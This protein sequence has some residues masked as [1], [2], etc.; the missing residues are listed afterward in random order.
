M[1]RS[2]IR[3]LWLFMVCVLFTALPLSP[4]V[5]QPGDTGVV[6]VTG[7]ITLTNPFV[8]DYSTEPYIAL[9]DLTAF[10]KRDRDMK[11]PY[12]D[13]TI[14]GL[15]GDLSTGAT[16]TMPLPIEPRGTLNNVSKGGQGVKIFSLDYDA[17]FVGDPF[18]GPFEWAGW[19]NGNDSLLFDPGTYE[20]VGGKMLVWSPDDQEMFPTGFGDDGKLFT[21]DDPVSSIG[22]GWT[23]IDLDK[24]PF[25]Q[26]RTPTADVPVLE[27]LAANNDLSKLSYT[28][29]FD[30]LVKDLRIRYPFTDYKRIDWDAIAKEIRPMVEQAENS[31]D[32]DAFNVAMMRFVSKLKDGHVSVSTDE[33]Y[34]NQQTAGG[35]GMVLGQADD[36]TVIARIVLDNLPAA[37]A[38]IKVGAKI[39][40]WNGQPI[41]QAL[42]NT[43]ILAAQS[44]PHG[45][46]LQQLRY[47]MRAPI[48]TKFTVKFQNPGESE[49][50]T[51]DVT[52]VKD[53]ESFRM[54]S[55]NVGLKPDDM[56]ITIKLLP[57]GNGYI[58]I[59]T[60]DGDGVLL[61]RTWEWALNRMKDLQVPAL[62]IDMRQNGGGTGLMATYF[63]GSFYKQSFILDKAYQADKTGKFVY[64]SRDEVA[65]APVQWDGPVAVLIGPAC[66]SACEIFS[67]AMAHD[68][69]HL[70]VGRYPTAG[71]E[72]SVEPWTLPDG[73]YFQAPT[74]RLVTPDDKIFLEGVGVL[75]NV[76]VP[77]T[78][79]SL[80]STDDQE[81]PAAEKALESLT[82]QSNN[83]TAEATAQATAVSTMEATAAP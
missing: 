4:A 81:L 27:G 19:S 52:T 79:E 80:L 44:S 8:I 34:F 74:G 5:A 7:K 72:A 12:P 51:A 15:Q 16:F 70:I 46:R 11:L 47:I 69:N 24:K 59:N 9:V 17:N 73:L 25:E 1:P 61:T 53:P 50:K 33:N 14:A 66:Y 49:A 41:D 3:S 2:A 37:G 60:F 45:I 26:I 13:Q 57:S 23:V 6:T 68:T 22:K 71:V 35:L 20:V 48:G 36:G 63:A 65:P 83:A 29:A 32:K 56:P 58:K 75:P 78:A 18:I 31:R 40:E 42:A 55:Q 30:A 21:A 28:Q 77:I 67:A 76:K 82:A 54:S 38:G 64:V 62:I 10:V 39:L 43:E